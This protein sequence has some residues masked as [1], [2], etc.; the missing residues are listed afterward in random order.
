MAI[1]NVTQ[2]WLQAANE[3]YNRIVNKL[4]KCA[5]ADCVFNFDND[6]LVSSIVEDYIAQYWFDVLDKDER[7]VC[8]NIA[9]IAEITNG[10]ALGGGEFEFY[11]QLEIEVANKVIETLKKR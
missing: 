6:Q 11:R 5:I 3:M 9:K 8:N 2:E 7:D 1:L 10:N 4:A